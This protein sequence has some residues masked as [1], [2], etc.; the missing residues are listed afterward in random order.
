MNFTKVSFNKIKW[1]IRTE[2]F[3]CNPIKLMLRIINWELIRKFNK[4][5]QFLFDQDLKI[6]LYP[7]DGVARL[8]YYFDYHE[9][10]I[11]KF[12]D[13]FLSNGM[14]YCD[15]GA[16]IGLYSIFAA[17]RVGPNGKVFSFEPQK[18][19]YQRLLENIEM[20]GLKN[21]KTINK[22]VGAYNGVAIIKQNEDSA[23]SYIIKNSDEG[24]RCFDKIEVINFDNFVNAEKLYDIDYLKIDVEGY[25]YNVLQGMTDFLKNKPPKIIQIELYESFLNRNGSSINQVKEFF[26]TLGYSF[27]KLSPEQ[28]KLI[29]ESEDLEGDIFVVKNEK[30]TNLLGFIIQ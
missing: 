21:I 27:F 18:E 3:K 28:N 11:F 22:A 6:Y 13:S 1:L 8:T 26:F 15:I 16:N 23:K 30:I 12:L 25:E 17:K 7:N 19:T 4:R 24:E 2:K 14:T 29:K 10:E 9:P 5:K 20:N